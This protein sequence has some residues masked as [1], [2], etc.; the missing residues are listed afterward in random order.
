MNQA[1]RLPMPTLRKQQRS[2]Q[3]LAE[4]RWG[5]L[6]IAPWILGFIIFIVGPMLA[7]LYFSFT[8]YSFPLTPR[9]IGLGN[10]IQAFSKDELFPT[11]LWNTVY[12]VGLSVPL[13]VLLS[14]ALALLMDRNIPGR[15]I[16]RTIYYLPSIVPTVAAAFLFLYI[17]QP[18]YGLINGWLWRLFAIEGPGWFISRVWVKPTLILLS[19]WAAGGPTMII[20]LAGLQ[21][22]P[23]ELYDAAEVD[24]A[25]RWQKFLNITLPMLSPTLFFVSVTGLIGAFKIFSA[26]YVS[27]GGGPFYGSYFYVLH[28]FTQAFRHWNLG[29]ASALAWILFV[30]ILILTLVQF[31]LA[32]RWVY[33]ESGMVDEPK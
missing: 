9:W 1:Q 3:A 17:F 32:G 25:G 30:I 12:Y 14:L 5:Y 16:W 15:P 6:F 19:L 33:Y 31:K 24:G 2:K 22:I 28:L 29:Y 13:G 27:T 20:I 11:S 10:Y 18:D 23:G 7:S 8:Q 26:A 4:E 21:G